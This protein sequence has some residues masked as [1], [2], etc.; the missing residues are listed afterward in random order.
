L[1]YV[2]ADHRRLSKRGML[3]VL[4][5][6]VLLAAG[7]LT[8][9]AWVAGFV[10]VAHLLAHP[11]WRW[12]GV[13]VA[14]VLVSYAGYLFAYREVVRAENGP[15]LDTTH[16]A[17]LVAAGF[18][19]FIPRG[20]FALDANAWS[21]G[22]LTRRE[23]QQRVLSL[24]IL[25]YALLAPATLVA[26]CIL[27]AH[28][29]RAQP[30]LLPSWVIGVPVGAAITL[31]LLALRGRIPTR[32]RLWQPLTH[33]LDAIRCTLQML[34]SR[35]AGPRAAIGM[36]LYWAGDIA[37]LGAC[38]TAIDGGRPSIAVLVVGYATGYALTRRSLPLAGAGAVEALLPFALSWVTLP[39]ASAVLAVF[40]YRLFNLW[41]PVVPAAAGLRHLR[42]QPLAPAT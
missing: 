7:A 8:G 15:D 24:A 39:L 13:A 12:L 33:W 21:E 36:A 34:R 9:V 31:T 32:G 30:G 27:F 37:A 23:A 3:V 38:F 42:R 4:I 25:E 16:A 19:V 40:A 17:A 22:H 2:D 28:H 5:T 6:A 41:L 26:P 10:T 11:D 29:L 1:S 18:G 14:G 35:P 20:G